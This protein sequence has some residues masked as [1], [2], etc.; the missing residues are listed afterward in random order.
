M[1]VEARAI[2]RC[3]IENVIWLRRLATEGA[4]FVQEIIADHRTQDIAFAKAILPLPVASFLAEDEVL[5]LQQQAGLKRQG[6]VSPS[7]KLQDEEARADYTLFKLLSG[8]AA[9][10][11]ARSLSWYL[12]DGVVDG[13]TEFHIEPQ[14]TTDAVRDIMYFSCGALVK[15]MEL[16]NKA[17]P[18]PGAEQHVQQAFDRVSAMLHPADA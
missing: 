18:R 1:V 17:V 15:A 5:H 2:T 14:V 16:Y 9:H 13:R 6:T 11:S 10:P 3:C 8:D 7:D 4:G 12:P